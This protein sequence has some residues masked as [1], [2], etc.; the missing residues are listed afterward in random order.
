[1]I[2]LMALTAMALP[3]FADITEKLKEAER[4]ENNMQEEAALKKYLEVLNEDPKNYEALW[5]TSLLY[6]KIGNRKDNEDEK[7]SYFN[8]AKDYAQRALNVN[9]NDA[10]SN[11]V[12]SVAMGRMALIV[13]AEERVAASRDIKKYADKAIKLNPKHAGAYHVLGIWNFKVANLNWAERVAANMLFGGIPEGASN[14]EAL[15]NFKKAIQLGPDYMLYYYD[16]GKFYD[17]TDDEAK[18]IETFEKL[19]A[20]PIATQDDNRIKQRSR[21][22]L[23]DLK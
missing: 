21:E 4:L 15:R 19:L 18:A 6:S 2:L 14:E 13:G 10:E 17:E 1:L 8:K 5:H 11:F 3:V 7:I 22:R 16:L 20:M 23:D 12:M 9:P